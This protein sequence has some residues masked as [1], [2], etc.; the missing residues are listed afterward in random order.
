MLT[1][2]YDH[3]KWVD[4]DDTWKKDCDE[5]KKEAFKNNVIEKLGLSGA[6]F[7][8]ALQVASRLYMFGPIKIMED[9]TIKD[10]HIQVSKYFPS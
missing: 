1:N 6:Q 9:V 8:G 3:S 5:I 10:R 7:G 2:K 4:E